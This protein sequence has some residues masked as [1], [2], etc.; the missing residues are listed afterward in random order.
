MAASKLHRAD[1]SGRV[2]ALQQAEA[3]TLMSFQR[4]A[5]APVI[6]EILLKILDDSRLQN[7]TETANEENRLRVQGARAV[8]ETLFTGKVELE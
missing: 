6:K 4:S 8:I 7:E 5:Y 1:T 2:I 3:R